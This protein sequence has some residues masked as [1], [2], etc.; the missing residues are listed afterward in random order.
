MIPF[1]DVIYGMFFMLFSENKNIVLFFSEQ[2]VMFSSY[3]EYADHQFFENTKTALGIQINIYFFLSQNIVTCE[4]LHQR[5]IL[6][7]L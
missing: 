5:I 7:I 6:R 3:H 4:N 2:C 1:I